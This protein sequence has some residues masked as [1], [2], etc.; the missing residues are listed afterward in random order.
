M[1]NKQT[2]DVFKKVASIRENQKR[3]IPQYV[4]GLKL[5]TIYEIC[6]ENVFPEIQKQVDQQDFFAVKLTAVLC[7]LAP[8]YANTIPQELLADCLQIANSIPGI[9]INNR[10]IIDV[11]LAFAAGW[12]RNVSVGQASW[13][14]PWDAA[15]E[16]LEQIALALID[17]ILIAFEKKKGQT[18]ALLAGSLLEKE[19][20]GN[21]VGAPRNFHSSDLTQV[22]QWAVESIKGFVQMPDAD[23]NQSAIY[24]YLQEWDPTH[25]NLS[26]MDWLTYGIQ[27]QH[28]LLKTN[29][30]K[31]E[32]VGHLRVGEFR[33]GY[34][35]L[36][37]S[38]EKGS[39]Y[40]LIRNAAFV[41]CHQCA[42][43]RVEFGEDSCTCGHHLAPR[44]FYVIQKEILLIPGVYIKKI[45]FRKFTPRT[46]QNAI[47]E[48]LKHRRK[49]T[50]EVYYEE[51]L[52][53]CPHDYTWKSTRL[54]YPYI[55]S[56]ILPSGQTRIVPIDVPDDLGRKEERRLLKQTILELPDVLK[57]IL[58]MYL[59]GQDIPEIAELLDLSEGRAEELFNKALVMLRS[60]LWPI[61]REA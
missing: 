24:R 16:Q 21:V 53:E 31:G 37:M 42:S 46:W 18:D 20:A 44:N 57:E 48:D 15:K 60:R 25:T 22:R 40:V 49:D 19:E 39:G 52:G 54:S 27:G 6:Q 7:Y 61:F 1:A 12:H 28:N 56:Y 29:L 13:D 10:L 50:I 55:R 35:Y 59:E 32:L 30:T 45:G 2:Q 26:L 11:A 36:L 5:R 14:K 8:S 4:P 3:P 51:G 9:H 58:R 33:H 43:E 47:L 23:I 38:A 34:L 41:K 17:R